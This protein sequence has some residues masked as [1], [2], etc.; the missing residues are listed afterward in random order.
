[1]S[2]DLN[3]YGAKVLWLLA[4]DG[5]TTPTDAMARDFYSAEGAN[6]GWYFDDAD[7]SVGA[8]T[9]HNSA[10]ISGVP[11]I[12][13]IDADTM[14]VAYDNPSNVRSAVMALDD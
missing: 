12:G 3:T 2:S 13:I 11:W 1:M 14:T 4:W 10:M 9:F 5:G 7:N 8:Y 6:F